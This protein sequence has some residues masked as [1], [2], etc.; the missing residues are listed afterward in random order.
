M[1]DLN[2]LMI[3]AKVVEAASFSQ[4][5]Q[6][7]SIPIS[8]VSRKVAELENELGVRLLERST[9]KLR[10]TDVGSEVLEQAQ[11]SVDINEAVIRL[12]SDKLLAVKGMLR[13]SAPPSIAD[14]VLGPMLNSFQVSY[15]EVNI[16]VLVTDRIVDHIAEGVDLVFRVGQLKD[17]NLVTRKILRY[18]HQLLA[19]PSYLENECIKH[20]QELL[21]HRLIAFSHQ[22]DKTNWTFTSSNKTETVYFQPHLAMNDYAGITRALVLGSGIGE[23]PPIVSSGLVENGTLVELMPQWQFRK[24]E[25]SIVHLGNRHISK[26]VRVF[27]DFACTKA[28]H[29]FD[30]FCL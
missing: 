20:P 17:S 5:A 27:K 29:L 11:R 8:T 30:Q 18:R 1:T 14:S 10:L 13:L 25:I 3:F 16:H 22:S 19:S 26:P 28:R 4:A 2:A 6:R 23:L 9:R 24:T 21:K 15:P 7:L 12:V